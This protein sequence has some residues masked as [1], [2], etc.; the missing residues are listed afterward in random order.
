MAAAPIRF[1]TVRFT[2]GSSQKY[3]FPVQAQNKAAVQLKLEDF[4]KGRHLVIQT[5]HHLTVF[6][7]ENVRQIEFS[8]G[9]GDDLEGVKLPAHTIRGASLVD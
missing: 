6:P 8:A 4:L 9:S 5:E 7:M 2:D 3:S 1:I